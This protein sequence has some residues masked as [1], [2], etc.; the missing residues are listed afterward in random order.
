MISFAVA[1]ALATI[2]SALGAT[3]EVQVGANGLTYTPEFVNAV[4]GDI[5]NFTFSPKN[6]TVTQ[7]SFD[8]PCVAAAG[9]ARTGFIPVAPGTSP[10]P[11]RQ[12]IVPES[13]A[14]IWFYCGQTAPVSH[15]GS[16]MVF[17]I[18][19]PAEGDPQ[20]FSAFK[21]RA[22]GQAAPT[23]TTPPAS[24]TTPPATSTAAPPTGTQATEH[25]IVVGGPN[26]ELTFTPSNIAAAV[27]DTVLF[28][29]HPKNHTVTQ[30]SF[31]QP[32]SPFASAAGAPGFRSGFQ[33]VALDATEFPTFSLL[34]ND[35][36]PIWGYC[37]QRSPISHCG[38]GMVFAIN[39]VE[40]GDNNFAAFQAAAR[41]AEGGSA[42]TGTPSATTS[43]AP[44]GGAL[45]TRASVGLTAGLVV[46]GF[47]ATFL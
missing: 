39:A 26:G 11:V 24:T 2:P 40:S 44:T 27:G 14:P 31:A 9:G 20:S 23:D 28:E 12:F 18:N 7:S 4:P 35:T 46:L 42:S 17:A 36:E 29:F 41:R 10:L 8:T 13:T 34:I 6:H 45:S 25:K 19:P 47:V 32:C 30:S 38:A 16:G 33:F 37:G 22:Q 1:L 3:F 43:P 21:A 15:C 5:V